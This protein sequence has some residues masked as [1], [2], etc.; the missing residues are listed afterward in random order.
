MPTFQFR[1]GRSDLVSLGPIVPVQIG[2]QLVDPTLRDGIFDTGASA[3]AIDVA[4]A[5]ELGLPQV[6][7][8]EISGVTGAATSP[9]YLAQIHIPALEDTIY[10]RL[11]GVPLL[12]S[13]LPYAAL[14]GRDFLREYVL[15]YDGRTG[16][17]V[18]TNDPDLVGVPEWL[19]KS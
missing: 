6:D 14:I 1:T 19:G 5:Q 18:I 9:V 11:A 13:G 16:A 10:G 12:A 7:E 15:M 2:F 8:A 17:V 4:L 3:S